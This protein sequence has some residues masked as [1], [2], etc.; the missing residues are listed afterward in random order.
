MLSVAPVGDP[1]ARALEVRISTESPSGMLRPGT[2][3]QMRMI[4]AE[5]RDA[6]VV[7]ASALL[8]QDQSARVFTV[9]DGKAR[10]QDVAIGI[11]DRANSEITRGLKVGDVVIVRSHV[12]LRDGQPVRVLREPSK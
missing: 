8:R 10:I 9:I 1:R 6:L 4:T 3:T 12:T 5:K 2:L 11:V 7:P